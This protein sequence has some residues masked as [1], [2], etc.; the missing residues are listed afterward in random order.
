MFNHYNHIVVGCFKEIF[1]GVNTNNLH[2]VLQAMKELNFIQANRAPKLSAH[3]GFPLEPHQIS[4]E[5]VPDFVSTYLSGPATNPLDHNK[6]KA[7]NQRQP[8]I[9]TFK[10]IISST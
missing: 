6:R 4:A 3:Y 1:Q 2:A 8:P 5:E 7:T 10:A 9:Q